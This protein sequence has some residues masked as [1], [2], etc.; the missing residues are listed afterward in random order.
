MYFLICM[1]RRFNC[2]KGAKINIFGS[3]GPVGE[4]IVLNSLL[5]IKLKERLWEGTQLD[6]TEIYYD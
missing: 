5:Y 2:R 3:E 1:G 4:A 6:L